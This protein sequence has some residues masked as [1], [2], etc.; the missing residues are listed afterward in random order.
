MKTVDVGKD[1]Y[2]RL[3]NRDQFQGDGKHT[4]VEFRNKYLLELDNKA[5]WSY[6]EQFIELDFQNVNKI[7]PSFAN[8]AFG[9]FMKY[10]DP[11]GFIRKVKFSNISEVHL[12]IIEEELESG[13]KGK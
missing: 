1:F 2:H 6:P 8:E 7:G 13:F 11:Q 4:A 3:A 12:M 10:T 9:Y 5:A